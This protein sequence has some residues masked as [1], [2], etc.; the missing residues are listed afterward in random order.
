MKLN[1]NRKSKRPT[2]FIQQGVHNGKKTTTKNIEI[3]GR[4]QELL[5]I[6]PDP[7]AYAIQ[8][9]KDFNNMYKEGRI[10]LN[11]KF[12]FNENLNATDDISSRSTVLCKDA[13][14]RCQTQYILLIDNK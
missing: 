7:L 9:V 2:Y 5:A 10:D 12:D 1:C 4:R 3:I 6:T 11:I 13:Q 8:Q 14:P